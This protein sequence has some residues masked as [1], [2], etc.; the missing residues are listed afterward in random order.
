MPNCQVKIRHCLYNIFMVTIDV[1][2]Q[3]LQ[4]AIKESGRTYKDIAEKVNIKPA[5]LSQY[6]SGRSMPALDTF[7]NLC[8]IL[9]LDPSYILGLSD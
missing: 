2:R 3:R 9:D 4:A 7:A 1:I 8:I 5:T 6:L